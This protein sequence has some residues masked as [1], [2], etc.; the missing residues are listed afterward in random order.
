MNRINKN[1]RERER[2]HTERGKMKIL[3]GQMTFGGN[4][5][6]MNRGGDQLVSSVQSKKK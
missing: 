1:R 6:S 2:E 3:N 4:W 5:I